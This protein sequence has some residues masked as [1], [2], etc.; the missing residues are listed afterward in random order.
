MI[1]HKL[2]LPFLI[3]SALLAGCTPGADFDIRGDWEYTMTDSGGN[4]YD[5]GVITFDGKPEKGT[6]I[7]VNIYQ[8]EYEGEFTVNGNNL[9]TLSGEETWQGVI[10]DADTINGTWGHEEEGSS[11]TFTASRK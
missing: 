8:V 9:L 5:M 7:E 3:I 6:Y 11:G 2:L 4:T 10:V 1:T